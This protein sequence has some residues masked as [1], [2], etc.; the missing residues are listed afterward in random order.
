MDPTVAVATEFPETWFVHISGYKTGDNL[1]TVF[2][3]IEEPRFVSGLIAGKMT[4]SNQLG[5]VAAFP[6]PEVV[7]GIN[8]FT[9]GVRTANPE[10]TVKVV[11]TNTWFDPVKEKEAAVALLAEG[12]DVIAQHQDTP[13]PQKAAEEQGKFGVG[14]DSDMSVQAPGAVLT[15][16]VWNWGPKYVGI[17]EAVMAGTYA[18]ESYWGGWQDNVVDLAPYGSMVPDDVKTMADGEIAKFKSGEQNIF[19]IFAGPLK[20]NTGAERVASGASMT[21][22]ELLGMDWFVDGVIGTVTQ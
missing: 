18:T 16:P 9:L 10:A 20:D 3:K 21:A 4:E 14:Y 8:A 6:I 22:E 15:S 12:C 2:G 13:E 5:Y 19:T 17:A 1:S 11:W 7:R